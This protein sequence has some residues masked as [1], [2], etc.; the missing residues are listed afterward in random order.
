M[1]TK[2]FKTGKMTY[3]A[4]VKKSGHS[5]EVSFLQGRRVLFLGSFTKQ[6]DATHWYTFMNREIRHFGRKFKVGPTFPTT[7]FN[8]FIGHYL[9]KRYCNFTARLVQR[10]SRVA[11]RK[12]RVGARRY[13][14]LNRNWATWEKRPV[15]KAA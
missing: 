4:S 14:T 7:W 6:S 10:D 2:T 8:H 9:T 3:K 1:K 5:Y 12:E 11:A 13:R 15:I